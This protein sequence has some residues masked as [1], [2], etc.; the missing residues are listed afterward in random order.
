MTRFFLVISIALLVAGSLYGL[1]E[2]E[3]AENPYSIAVTTVTR[4]TLQS[5]LRAMGKLASSHKREIQGKGDML[6]SKIY[7]SEG[8]FV[9]KG[10]PIAKITRNEEMEKLLASL[11]D[12]NIEAAIGKE[13]FV[14]AKELRERKAVAQ[15]Q[16]REAQIRHEKAETAVER[17]QN[18]AELARQFLSLASRE[19]PPFIMISPQNGKIIRLNLKEGEFQSKTE[20][21]LVVIAD[22]SRLEVIAEIAPSDIA[23]VKV[24][25]PIEFF[26]S[27]EKTVLLGEIRA[28]AQEVSAAAGA[29]PDMGMGGANATI[30][31]ICKI[32][33]PIPAK[34]LKLGITGEVRILTDVRKDVIV[35]PADT[36]LSE[37]SRRYVYVV[38]EG[39]AQ[40]RDIKIGM[41]TQEKAEVLEGL[42]VNEEVVTRGQFLLYD[43]AEVVIVEDSATFGSKLKVAEAT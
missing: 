43:Q 36:I 15:N 39:R 28:I 20:G 42:S 11:R 41:I 29:I 25:R 33:P 14:V 4:E 8:A 23:H 16:F 26:L 27:E 1:S 31:V 17:I 22:M 5:D 10:D 13:A 19:G 37:G 2:K 7:V 9:K 32:R 35:I 24:G 30:R 3:P 6:V 34:G 40:R 38:K 21:P 18:E 12:A